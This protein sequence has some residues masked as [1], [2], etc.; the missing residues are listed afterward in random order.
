MKL[1]SLFSAYRLKDY[2]QALSFARGDQDF[3]N[4]KSRTNGMPQASPSRFLR[5][6]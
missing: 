5:Q 4:K 6:I 2:V 3:V 1:L